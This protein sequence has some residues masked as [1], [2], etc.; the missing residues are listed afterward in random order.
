[1][2]TEGQRLGRNIREVSSEALRAL[3]E[4]T[5]PGNIRELRNV[6]ERALVLAEGEVLRLPGP[7]GDGAPAAPLPRSGESLAENVAHHLG[8][9]SLQEILKL[10]KKAL[11][12][13][14]LQRSEGNQ[15]KAAEIL[16]LHR[17]SLSRMIRDL[18]IK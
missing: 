16:G 1:M 2:R 12:E 10:Y 15:S 7:L 17:P 5:W 14:A 6:I 3:Q 11:I 9:A 13:S 4:W 18:G 8:S